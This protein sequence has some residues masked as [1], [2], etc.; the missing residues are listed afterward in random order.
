VHLACIP[1]QQHHRYL[2]AARSPTSGGITIHITIHIDSLAPWPRI[3]CAPA[4][5]WQ[6][7]RLVTA[8]L[9]ELLTDWLTDSVT[10][11]HTTQFPHFLQEPSFSFISSGTELQVALLLSCC[12]SAVSTDEFTATNNDSRYRDFVN[13][14]LTLCCED[15]LSNEGKA[16]SILKLDCGRK[17]FQLHVPAALPMVK[18]QMSPLNRKLGGTQSESRRCGEEKNPWFWRESN[19]SCPARRQPLHSANMGR[20]S[21]SVDLNS[22]SARV[23]SV[24]GRFT[25]VT[26]HLA[27]SQLMTGKVNSWYESCA[28]AGESSSIS[29]AFSR[30]SSISATDLNSANF[31]ASPNIQNWEKFH[32]Q[33]TCRHN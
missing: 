1:L 27:I 23:C 12:L 4:D 33:D 14:K 25:S 13:K 26:C 10:C 32:S 15:A 6:S 31:D 8:C 3:S 21:P 9:S 28:A 22:R 18:E 20:F 17:F 2:D 29:H 19:P 11:C 24:T 16:P 30:N 7:T 5:C